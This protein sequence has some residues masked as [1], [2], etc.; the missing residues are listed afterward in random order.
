MAYS[1]TIFI[2]EHPSLGVLKDLEE[3][4]AGNVGR[5]SVEGMRGDPD[6]CAIFGNVAMANRAR[7]LI[8]P[9]SKRLGCQIRSSEEA[10]VDGMPTPWPVVA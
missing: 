4:D 10:V 1:R 7:A 8:T 6:S 3:T 2:I 5:F 9:R